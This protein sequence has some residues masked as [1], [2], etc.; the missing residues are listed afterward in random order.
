MTGVIF[1]S[2]I[3]ALL[4]K[5][6]LAGNWSIVPFSKS[7]Y[8]SFNPPLADNFIIRDDEIDQ[9]IRD[10]TGNSNVFFYK[11][12]YSA[13]GKLV[14][15]HDNTLAATWITKVFGADVPG[16]VSPYLAARMVS[17]IYATKVNMLYQSLLHEFL[18][19]L[20]AEA[21]KGPV[22]EVGSH[23]YVR[24]GIRH[25]FDNLINTVPLPAL[26]Q[27]L[28]MEMPLAARTEHF[29]LVKSNNIDLEGCNQSY[30]VDEAL[31]FYRV[32][33]L[34]PKLYMFYF[35]KEVLQPGLYLLPII[36][37]ADIIDGTK[38]ADSLPTGPMPDLSRLDDFGIF[39]VG[40]QAQWDWC[41]DVGSNLLRLV[42]YA[43]RA[44]KP[45]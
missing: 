33:A 37:G 29:V 13:Q 43:A 12:C 31:D 7:R 23:Y 17:P 36:G 11:R 26:L 2:G 34:A 9:P 27:L 39:N 32:T 10:L 15:E 44:Y 20:R 18:P 28:K 42:R 6:I 38:I 22:T 41:A 4:A 24:G 25:D 45:A 5:K 1:G 30:V 16:Q 3:V 40:A 8:Y 21:A 19:E 35:I 14:K